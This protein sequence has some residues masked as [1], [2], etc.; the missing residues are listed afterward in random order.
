M[1]YFTLACV[2]L[3]LCYLNACASV[4]ELTQTDNQ[5]QIIQTPNQD[6]IDKLKLC[7]QG[8]LSNFEDLALAY[9]Q[10]YI[11]R[12][13][14]LHDHNIS[15]LFEHCYAKAEAMGHQTQVNL[16][17]RNRPRANA[18]IARY[19]YAN[20]DTV[21]GQYYLDKVIAIEGPVNGYYRA[22]NLFLQDSKT[23]SIAANLML[24]AAL[25]GNIQAQQDLIDLSNPSSFKFRRLIGIE[26]N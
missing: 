12:S 10:S 6:Y 13:F 25:L 23:L 16:K 18:L 3:T 11:E 19:F 5:K 20:N 21:N 22:A 4:D 17:F 2:I 24:Q 9:R 7:I 26:D 14:K 15:L 1:K 8:D